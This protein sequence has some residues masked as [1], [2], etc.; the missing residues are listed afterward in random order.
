MEWKKETLRSLWKINREK[1]I[2]IFCSGLL[3]FLLSLPGDERKKNSI[4][5][6]NTEAVFSE[7]S[8]KSG[9]EN[10]ESILESRIREILS[11][12]DG[13][14]EVDVMVVTRSSEEKILHV[15]KNTSTSV[16]EEKNSTASSR[17]LSQQEISENTVMGGQDQAP[18]VEKELKPEIS[19]IVISADGGGSAVVKAEI[20]E[21]M[22]ALF[23]L[24]AHKI[25]VL[26][27]VKKGV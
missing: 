4:P 11:G 1:L 14:G 17:I 8:E 21:A 22:E 23:G 7:N 26:K 12:V 6:G 15:D 18:I 9:A 25:K 2:F 16:T 19:G 13:V 24:P 27:R 5:A 20:C 10:Y 3:L